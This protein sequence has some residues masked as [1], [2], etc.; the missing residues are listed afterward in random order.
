MLARA[1]QVARG[2]DVLV[3]SELSQETVDRWS[4]ARPPQLWAVR[5]GTL[6]HVAWMSTTGCAGWSRPIT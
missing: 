5:S 2:P 6:S 4:P 3:A 1:A